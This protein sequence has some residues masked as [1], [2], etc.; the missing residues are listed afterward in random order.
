MTA[1][2][3]SAS[4][5]LLLLAVFHESV[6][7]LW[8][9]QWFCV[10]VQPPKHPVCHLLDKDDCHTCGSSP[11]LGNGPCRAVQAPPGHIWGRLQQRDWQ[12]TVPDEMITYHIPKTFMSGT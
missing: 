9:R 12:H 11:T 3:T 7:T 10:T 4:N 1:G 8:T 6:F 2:D 5:C